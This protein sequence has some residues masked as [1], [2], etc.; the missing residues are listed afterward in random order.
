MSNRGPRADQKAATRAR[1]LRVARRVFARSGFA[2]TS[3]AMICREAQVTHGALYHHFPG[4]PALFAAVLEELT[5]DVAARVQ[6]AAERATGWQQVEAACDAYL[7]ACTDPA[8]QAIVVRDGPRALP[9]PPVSRSAPA[10]RGPRFPR[11]VRGPARPAAGE[12]ER[13]TFDAIDHAVNEPLV[14][15]LLHRWIAAGLLRP[16][17]VELAARVLGGAFAE[18]SA[19]IATAR[20]PRRVR[21]ELGELFRCWLSAMRADPQP[22]ARR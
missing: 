5:A 16:I 20:R 9:S 17:P 15:G 18:A 21:A 19:A 1:L 11:A 13:A 2:G 4:K 22:A 3:V 14:A 7:D 8:V 6:R 10:P 12:R